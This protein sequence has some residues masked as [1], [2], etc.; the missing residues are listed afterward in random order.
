MSFGNI[1]GGEYFIDFVTHAIFSESLNV[2]Q[3]LYKLL[4]VYFIDTAL[5]KT[6][7]SVC[8]V[9]SIFGLCQDLFSPVSKM[10]LK[11]N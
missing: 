9:S 5:C 1:L 8:P 11:M 7:V 10:T 2:M 4:C 6:D 3:I